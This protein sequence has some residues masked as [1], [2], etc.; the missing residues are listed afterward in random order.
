MQELNYQEFK[1]NNM[2]TKLIIL[3]ILLTPVITLFAQSN[4]ELDRF[5]NQKTADLATSI[6]L[7]YLS[8][9]ELP[10]DSIPQDAVDKL[11]QSKQGKRFQGSDVSTPITYGQFA[12][13]MM[14]S[15]DLP[16]G[17]MYTI[18]K[19]PRY[20]ASE[21]TYKKWMPGKPKP[22]SFLT[23]WE[24]TSSISQVMAWKEANR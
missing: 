15:Y 12:M 23:P 16:G 17:L 5:L 10:Q 19:N 7:V 8:V 22:N 2:K 21:F 6:W 1:E 11:L 9:G 24:V 14:D 4:I 20:A 18:Y 3:L 13:L